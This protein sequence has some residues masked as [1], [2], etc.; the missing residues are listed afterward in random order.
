MWQ[1]LG[2]LLSRQPRRVKKARS[3]LR[4]PRL[5]QRLQLRLRGIWL[6]WDRYPQDGTLN[7]PFS[8][9]VEVRGW[10]VAPGGV[11]SVD[12][13]CDNEH[14]GAAAI[15]LRR[16]DLF[17]QFPHVRS[18]R[19]GGFQYVF[20]TTRVPNGQHELT[21]VA[22][23]ARGRAVRL[24]API[25]VYNLATR[26]E[27]YR[28]QTATNAAALA[29]MRRNLA[30]LPIRPCISLAVTVSHAGD[31]GYLQETVRSLTAQA[32]GDWELLLVCEHTL[33]EPTRARILRAVA[34][35]DRVRWLESDA[36]PQAERHAVR[37]EASGELFGLLDPGDTLTPD[38]LFEMVYYLNRHPET[39]FVYSDE[40]MQG[41]PPSLFPSQ[42]GRRYAPIPA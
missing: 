27:R 32:Y 24:S 18:A 12:V 38:A 19:R 14:L 8:G 21:L 41:T 22:R 42:T 39:D 33:D 28:R 31:V 30:H 23:G 10:A 1:V 7:R 9:V 11:R 26:H 2:K 5:A 36:T 35:E 15:G 17:Y 6:H 37:R 16:R 34:R 4:R 13:H 29:W 40:E 3:W 20:D 25:Y